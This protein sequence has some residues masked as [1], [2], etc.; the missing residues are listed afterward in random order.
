VQTEQEQRRRKGQ[1]L[2]DQ[3]PDERAAF[4]NG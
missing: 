2:S 4:F 1:K 3:Q